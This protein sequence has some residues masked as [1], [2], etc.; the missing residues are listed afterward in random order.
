MAPS[1]ATKASLIKN[2]ARFDPDEATRR[3]TSTPL[4]KPELPRAVPLAVVSSGYGF[5]PVAYFWIFGSS[6]SAFAVARV[7]PN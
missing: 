5:H 4:V 7:V 3:E 1:D 2:I 6:I